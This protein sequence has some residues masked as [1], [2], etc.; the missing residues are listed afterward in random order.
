MYVLAVSAAQ[1]LEWADVP[2]AKAD[3]MAGYQRVYNADRARSIAEFLETDPNNVIPGAIIVTVDA[4]SVST[5]SSAVPGVDDIAIN[6]TDRAFEDL[7][8]G[9]YETFLARLSDAEKASAAR[10]SAESAEAEESEDESPENS[11]IPESYLATLTAELR[12]AQDNYKSLPPERQAAIRNYVQTMSKPGLIIDGQHRVFGGK[13]VASHDVMLP[14]VLLP[15]LPVAEQVFHFYVLNNKAKPLTPT[16]LRRTISTSLTNQEI[17]GLWDRFE[18]A[19]VNPEATRWTHKMDADPSSPFLHLLDFGLGASG[20]LRENVAFQLVSKFVNMPRKYRLLYKD[21]PA[22]QNQSDE[23]LAYFFTFWS[24]VR[25]RYQSTWDEGVRAGGN[26]LFMKA[27]MLVLQELV[28]DFLVQ[29]MTVRQIEGKPSP[30]A[31]RDDLADL[32]VASLKY[33]PS[34]FFSREW[35]EK[36]LD[37]SERRAF[38]RAQMEITIRNQGKNIGNQQLFKKK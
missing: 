17:D 11:G 27:G 13:D 20:F 32:V 12:E 25:D 10:P 19:G 29:V 23:R 2:N 15:G 22:W 4:D 6:V 7:L 33:L 1:L 37:T 21:V 14:V 36:Q 35:Q 9:V 5:H 31:D 34:E 3:Y 26:Q 28:L 16:E 8:S 30:F 38:L 24:A 18:T